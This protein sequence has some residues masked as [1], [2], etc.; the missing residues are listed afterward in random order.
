MNVYKH[1]CHLLVS[2][3]C[4]KTINVCSTGIMSSD[5]LKNWL[6][7][8]LW[9]IPQQHLKQKQVVKSMLYPEPGLK[10]AF[11]RKECLWIHFSRHNLVTAHLFWCSIVAQQTAK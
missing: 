4:H 6:D 7:A 9:R 3:R 10:W 1:K 2:G 5:S 11:L 8:K